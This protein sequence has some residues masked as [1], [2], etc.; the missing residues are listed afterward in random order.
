MIETTIC[1]D[2]NHST[3]RLLTQDKPEIVNKP[4]DKFESVLFLPEGENRKGEGGLRTKGYFKKSYEDKPLI[5]IV[6]VV[7]NGEAFLEETILSVIN[8]SYDNVE[9]IIIDGGSTDGTLE[10]VKKYEHAINYW[11]SE[12]DSGIYDAMN[13]GIDLVSGEWINFMN[14]GDR[15]VDSNTIQIAILFADGNDLIYSD[16]KLSNGKVFKCEIKQNRIIHQSL[17]YKKRL[18]AKYGL[19]VLSKEITISDYL[20]F[21][22]CKNEKWV[23]IDKEISLF[24]LGGTS[25]NLNHFKQKIAVDIMFN[26]ISRFKAAIYLIV[27]PFYNK[28]KRLLK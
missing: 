13:K 2:E 1:L 23:K 18:H 21:M 19:Y 17:I 8:Q 11:V 25:S 22:L 20:F 16:T 9:Y 15:L 3:T 6:T 12:K 5:S 14:A 7:Y 28:I 27:H 4:E 26:N 24:E 10:I